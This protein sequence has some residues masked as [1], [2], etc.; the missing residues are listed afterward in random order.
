MRRPSWTAPLSA[1]PLSPKTIARA[2][3]LREIVVWRL[4]WGKGQGEGE[5]RA[6]FGPLTLPSPPSTL[7]QKPCK[8]DRSC[9]AKL[10]GERGQSGAVQLVPGHGSDKGTGRAQSTRKLLQQHS[11]NHR[12]SPQTPIYPRFSI[13]HQT[14]R[15]TDP[16]THGPTDPPTPSRVIVILPAHEPHLAE[17]F[18]HEDYRHAGG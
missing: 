17:E 14:H 15:L 4:F 13:P 6:W 18:G 3:F 12:P 10:T 5:N 2:R 16:P 7:P 1:N 9:A 11:Y 8:S